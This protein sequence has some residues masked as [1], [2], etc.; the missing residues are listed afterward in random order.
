MGVP[1]VG[2]SEYVPQ[3]FDT[4]GVVSIIIAWTIKVKVENT[5]LEE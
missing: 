3:I 1:K 2:E 4:K 5:V